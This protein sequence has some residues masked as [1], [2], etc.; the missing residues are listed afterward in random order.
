MLR[1]HGPRVLGGIGAW[2]GFYSRIG[3]IY[4]VNVARTTTPG[5]RLNILIPTMKPAAIYGG[6]ATALRCGAALFE[7]MEKPSEL[8]VIVT[9]DDVDPASMAELAT[10]LRSTFA[11][12]EPND[13]VAGA[14][15]PGQTDTL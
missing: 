13:D 5:Q 2:S 10:R 7:A 6:I 4:P 8:R 9:N 3:E 14:L 1:R 11:L 12:A 15:I